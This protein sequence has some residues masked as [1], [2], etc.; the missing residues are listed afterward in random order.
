M[1]NIL[2]QVTQLEE[3]MIFFLASLPLK[4]FTVLQSIYKEYTKGK[5]KGQAVSR[6]N[7]GIDSVLDLK[8]S[9]FKPFRNLDFD[10]IHQLL[11][12]VNEKKASI[13]EAVVKCQDI[14][15]LQKIQAAFVK[16]MN[17]EDWDEA[18]ERFPDFATAEKL[19]PFKNLDFSNST[20]LPDRFL[21]FCQ[22][23]K[24]IESIP[25]GHQEHDGYFAIFHRGFC[26]NKLF[27]T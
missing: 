22:Q 13:K 15:A 6:S 23:A 21:N 4:T 25:C 27:S 7:K 20:R 9:T 17:C 26:G 8:G 2:L 19:E 12:E 18:T 24:E 3:R 14:K 10:V 5:L 11:T 16:F 1:N